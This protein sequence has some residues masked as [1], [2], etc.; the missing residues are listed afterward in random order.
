AYGGV[1]VAVAIGWLWWVERMAPTRW[2]LIGTAITLA[3][4]AVIVMQPQR[5]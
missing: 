2:D 4:M 1:Y 3:G 5:V